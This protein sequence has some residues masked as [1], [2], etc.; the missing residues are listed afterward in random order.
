MMDY[1]SPIKAS[2]YVISLDRIKTRKFKLLK[3]ENFDII[4]QTD[5]N[6]SVDT[7]CMYRGNKRFLQQVGRK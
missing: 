5:R 6:F 2:F 1:F 3:I 7:V 4:F